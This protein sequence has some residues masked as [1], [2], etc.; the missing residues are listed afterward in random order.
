MVRLD[1]QWRWFFEDG[2]TIDLLDDMGKM[3]ASLETR[4]PGMGT[5]YKRLM[6]LSEELH[7]ISDKFFFSKS[8]GSIQD[9]FDVRGAFDIKVLRDVLKMRMG[10][11]AAD[12]IRE[13]I[14]EPN[15]AQMLDHMVQYVGSSPDASPAILT[16]IGHV[17]MQEGIWYPNGRVR[18]SGGPGEARYGARRD[19]PHQYGCGK[20]SHYERQASGCYGACDDR[21]N[22]VCVRRHREQ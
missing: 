11:S 16:A 7:T 20:D 10:K 4:F 12:T 13:F 22:G 21:W 14:H 2:A 17:Q 1:P 18:G 19:L 8:V 3:S 9:A 6:D 15:T 5:K